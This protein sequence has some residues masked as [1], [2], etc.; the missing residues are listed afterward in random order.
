MPTDSVCT[1]P[2]CIRICICV[3]MLL[4]V[5]ICS[6]FVCP[7]CYRQ[8]PGGQIDYP[9][10]FV[11][12]TRKRFS[13][14]RVCLG[15]AGE[16]SIKS[17]QRSACCAR[18]E[19]VFVLFQAQVRMTSRFN[20]DA[21]ARRQCN[22]PTRDATWYL[23]V[24]TIRFY[25]GWAHTRNK[26]TYIC[27]CVCIRLSITLLAN[28]KGRAPI[29]ICVYAHLRLCWVGEREREREYAA[30]NGFYVGTRRTSDACAVRASPSIVSWPNKN[31]LGS[32]AHTC[33]STPLVRTVAVHIFAEQTEYVIVSCRLPVSVCVYG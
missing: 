8:S 26:N 32:I 29:Q 13:C 4:C 33:E 18:A 9:N 6:R 5:Q 12:S 23:S 2:I 17:D 14:L 30:D 21:A 15:W 27:A 28:K 1:D 16:L 11:A 25:M 19:N 22:C 10:W 3:W 24:C 7:V 20:R 31:N